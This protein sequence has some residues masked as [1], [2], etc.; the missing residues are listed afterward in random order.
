MISEMKSTSDYKHLMS[1][2]F[3][4]AEEIYNKTSIDSL[5]GWQIIR[6][7]FVYWSYSTVYRRHADGSI[8]F[9]DASSGYSTYLIFSTF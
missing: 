7:L 9:W 5:I 3:S 1:D 6:Y 2:L 4:S 8:K